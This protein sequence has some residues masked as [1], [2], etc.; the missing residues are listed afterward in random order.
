MSPTTGTRARPTAELATRA[1]IAGAVAAAMAL[2][3]G[4]LVSAF[5]RH[6]QSLVGGVG[7]EIVDR[8]AGGTVR[9]AIETFGT[10]DK[11]VL[12][13]TIVVLSLL[14]GAWLGRLSLTRPWAG[15]VGFSL[16]GL[17]GTRRRGARSAE[18]GRCRGRAPR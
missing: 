14:L 6:G 7:N 18:L 12:V 15:P 11:T 3:V 13:I 16:F 5:G 2:A 9:F 17:L 1:R 4:E 10:A 8:A